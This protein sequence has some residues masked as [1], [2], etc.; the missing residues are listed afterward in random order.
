MFCDEKESIKSPT[1]RN[2]QY[3]TA[4]YYVK[5]GTPE[6]FPTT[7]STREQKDGGHSPTHA[8]QASPLYH[9]N[10]TREQKDGGH[11]PTHALQASPLYHQN[12]QNGYVIGLHYS[13]QMTG[14]TMNF[15]SLQC[16]AYSLGPSVR[17]VEPFLRR[18]CLGVDDEH[19]IHMNGT[20]DGKSVRLS[21]V[22]DMEKWREFTDRHGGYSPLASW[23]EFLKNSPRKMIVVERACMHTRGCMSCGDERTSDL[24]QSIKVLENRYGFKTVRKVCHPMRLMFKKDFRTLVYQ[25]YSANEVVVVFNVWGGVT[26]VASDAEWRILIS[27][28]SKKCHTR[29]RS[30]ENFGIL[31]TPHSARLK[32]DAQQYINKYLSADGYIS[33]MIRMEYYYYS[34]NSLRGM[35]EGR[36]LL[37]LDELYGQITER[38]NRLK[39]KFNVNATLL[40][41]DCRGQGSSGFIYPSR[42]F[43]LLSK[44]TSRLYRKLY[45]SSSTL[46]EWDESF[47]SISSFRNEGYIAM[48]QKYLAASGTCLITSGGGEFQSNARD[49]YNQYHST[50][51]CVYII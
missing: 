7:S 16:W 51:R 44:S 18:S 32:H 33:I 40:T 49:M 36:I 3:S 2:F 23:D 37:D 47:Y 1:S 9:Q 45:G 31:Q 20:G 28:E 14:S 24:L 6:V 29:C 4:G 27:D 22:Y 10:P 17:V 21:D 42:E 25:N 26:P 41:M 12:P 38:V 11:S 50:K 39:K 19:R 46:A 34:H 5:H 43:A 15:I 30:C 35:S 8:L 13:D 48:L